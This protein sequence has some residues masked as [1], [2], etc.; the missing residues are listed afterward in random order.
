LRLGSRSRD[1]AASDG[2]GQS[3]KVGT[4]VVKVLGSSSFKVLRKTKEGL[5]EYGSNE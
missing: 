2:G 3:E 5:D 4:H 1:R